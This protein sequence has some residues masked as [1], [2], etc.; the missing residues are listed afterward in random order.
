[1]WLSITVII[2]K[3]TDIQQLQ[4]KIVNRKNA[5]SLNWSLFVSIVLIL[6]FSTACS[7]TQSIPSQVNVLQARAVP[8]T[9]NQSAASQPQ[10]DPALEA[11]ADPVIVEESPISAAPAGEGAA[12]ADQ[13]SAKLAAPIAQGA[14][15]ENL[16]ATV[17][18]DQPVAAANEPLPA[19][20]DAEP[21]VGSIAPDFTLQTLNG[22]S[23]NLSSLRGQNVLINYWV[24][25]CDPCLEE[26]PTLE[27]IYK[28]YEGKDLV[29]L[30][31]NGIAQDDLNKVKDTVSSLGL[32]YPVVLDEGDTVFKSYWMGFMP[33]SVFIDAQGVIRFIKFGGADEVEFRAKIDQLLAGTL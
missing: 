32:T 23:I 2:L 18:Q 31:I 10:D 1:M 24:T 17:S 5:R 3:L 21:T 13:P 15:A 25:W 27:K 28:E 30:S 14:P 6:V 19:A 8:P 26:M 12:T 11:S 22:S 29:I 16:P 9:V 4:E 20:A 7:S 33:T